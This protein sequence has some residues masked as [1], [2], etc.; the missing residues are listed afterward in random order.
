MA[1]NTGCS[2]FLFIWDTLPDKLKNR[3]NREGRAQSMSGFNLFVQINM[4]AV[5]T[6]REYKMV[7]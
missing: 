7:P 4:D 2:E 3:W 5:K 1:R 6:G